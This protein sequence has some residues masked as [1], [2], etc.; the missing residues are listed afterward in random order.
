MERTMIV[1]CWI[2]GLALLV[3]IAT[4]LGYLLYKG[5]GTVNL[6]LIFGNTPP[7]DALL[8][9]KH[10][11]AGLFPAMVGTLA[12]VTLSVKIADESPCGT[13]FWI[14]IASSSVSKSS[15]RSWSGS[16]AVAPRRSSWRWKT[17][18]SSW[19]CATRP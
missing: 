6:R 17:C 15:P 14:A 13:S 4:I 18:D 11:F 8:L 12:V 9:R 10:V 7:V 16:R 2:C 5:L 3:A 1:F 19:S